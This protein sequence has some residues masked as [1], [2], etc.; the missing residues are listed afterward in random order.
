MSGSR[1]RFSRCSKSGSPY[2]VDV[3]LIQ[4]E[5]TELSCGMFFQITKMLLN[6]VLNSAKLDSLCNNLKA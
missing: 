3:E 1:T 2:S 5:K 4:I 6:T